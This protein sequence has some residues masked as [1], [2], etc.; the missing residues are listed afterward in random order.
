MKKRRR[1]AAVTTSRADFGNLRWLLEE[2]QRDRR[3][4][5]Q[6]IVSGMHLDAQFGHTAGE[7]EQAGPTETVRA[8]VADQLA[9]DPDRTTLLAMVEQLLAEEGLLSR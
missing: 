9:E 7:I 2:I 8:F 1:I 6:L 4:E 3:L 5:L